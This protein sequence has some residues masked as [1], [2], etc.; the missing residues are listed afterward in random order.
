[1]AFVVGLYLVN[2]LVMNGKLWLRRVV[3]VE[4]DFANIQIIVFDIV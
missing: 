1:M 3:V 2:V 4:L